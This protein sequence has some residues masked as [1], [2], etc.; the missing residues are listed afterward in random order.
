MNKSIGFIGAG[1]MG[2]AI[3]KG[4]IRNNL[5]S[6]DK[7]CVYDKNPNSTEKLSADFGIKSALSLSDVCLCDIVILAV[8]PDVIYSVIDTG[9]ANK[10]KQLADQYYLLSV[11]L[12]TK[13]N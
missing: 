7:I 2:G 6:A 10:L 11:V 1:N 9:F 4:M 3:I 5:V 13:N 8:K 12:L